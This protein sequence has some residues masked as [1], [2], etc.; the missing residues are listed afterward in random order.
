MDQTLAA[1]K[2]IPAM[3]H[4]TRERDSDVIERIIR[5]SRLAR[6]RGLLSLD[7]EGEKA[8]DP[9]LRRAIRLAVDAVGPE[10]MKHVLDA[11]IAG[12]RAQ[13]E[14][15]A[16][17][18]ETAAGYAPTL[19][20]AGAAIGLVQVMKHLDHFEQ[21]GMGVASAFVATIYGVLLANLVLLPVA[22]KIRARSEA[23]ARVCA[24][25]REG[26]ISISSGMNPSL[27][28]MKLEAFAQIPE[29][30]AARAAKLQTAA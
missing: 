12:M 2:M 3:L 19:G 5:Y 8:G 6:Q 15:A 17:F 21:V 22:T 25:M 29:H 16:A 14:S 1:L 24:L 11:D 4:S 7:Q 10:M 9:F 28:R 18:Y 20:V 23:R 13:A 26:A 30:K 27:I